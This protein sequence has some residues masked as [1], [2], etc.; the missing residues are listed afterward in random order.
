MSGHFIIACELSVLTALPRF[1]ILVL[2]VAKEHEFIYATA[3][4]RIRIIDVIARGRE[5]SRTSI[6]V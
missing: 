5:R 6:D 4:K 2:D 1:N 3:E